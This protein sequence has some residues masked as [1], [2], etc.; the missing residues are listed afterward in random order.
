MSHL[1]AHVRTQSDLDL[2]WSTVEAA[3]VAAGYALRHRS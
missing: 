1:L 2:A 3:V